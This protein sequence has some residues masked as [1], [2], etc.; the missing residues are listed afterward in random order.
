MK[1]QEKIDLLRRGI[2]ETAICR[3]RFTYD[4][5]YF[6][7]YPHA[8]SERFVLGREEDDFMLDGYSIRKLSQLK[9]VELKDDKCGEINRIFGITDQLCDPGIS[10]DGWQS[11]FEALSKIDGYLLIEDEINGQFAI[12]VVRKVLKNRVHFRSFDADGIWDEEDMEIPYS[13]IT[14]VTWGNR[15][16]DYW[17]RYFDHECAKNAR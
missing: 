11:I 2:A 12:G 7:Y 14:S 13:Q 6:Y 16:T 1:K 10:L 17:K 3:C 8:V 15:Y 4:E 5:N 9:K